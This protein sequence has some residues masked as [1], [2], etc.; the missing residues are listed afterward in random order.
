M[1][2]NVI[3]IIV[4]Q[5]FFTFITM[6][7]KSLP[8]T[9]AGDS[10]T[11]VYLSYIVAM[12]NDA[13]ATP[14]GIVENIMEGAQAY[15]ELYALYEKYQ[16]LSALEKTQLLLTALG[17]TESTIVETPKVVITTTEKI[18]SPRARGVVETSVIKPKG[19]TPVNIFAQEPAPVVVPVFTPVGTPVEVSLSKISSSPFSGFPSPAVVLP[20]VGTVMIPPNQTRATASP[21]SRSPL[22]PRP[23][24]CPDCPQLVGVVSQPVVQPVV[25]TPQPRKMSPS[26]PVPPPLFTPVSPQFTPVEGFGF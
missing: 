22:V 20:P 12:N 14:F 1:L 19:M 9:K 18:L 21:L 13:N 17:G 8:Q 4:G 11:A 7:S 5:E 26:P 10:T 15:P 3:N 23:V 6:M 24:G 2:N 25:V 16:S